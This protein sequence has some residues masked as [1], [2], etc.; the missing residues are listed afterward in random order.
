[1]RP[2]LLALAFTAS[3]VAGPALAGPQGCS[4]ERSAQIS[5][6]DGTT[7]DE[8]EKRCITVGS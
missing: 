7:W 2:A 4:H 3:A 5:C 6:A 1:M 8:T